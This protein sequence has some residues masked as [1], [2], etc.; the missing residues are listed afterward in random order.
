VYIG[1]RLEGT[2]SRRPVTLRSCDRVTLRDARAIERVAHLDAGPL[3]AALAASPRI[4]PR[5]LR[6]RLSA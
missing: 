3:I 4:W 2:I 1:L 6:Q 5:L